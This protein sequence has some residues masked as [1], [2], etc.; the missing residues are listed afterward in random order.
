MLLNLMK[1]LSE[2]FVYDLRQFLL[3][4]HSFS[5]VYLH[6]NGE[7]NYEGEDDHFVDNVFS[8][9][10]GYIQWAEWDVK[11]WEIIRVPSAPSLS[12]DELE[13]LRE[14]TSTLGKT[15]PGPSFISSGFVAFHISRLPL[16]T[17]YLLHS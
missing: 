14:W 13:K 6:K 8:E 4:N 7:K 15:K 11:T 12:N 9:P 16:S 10:D 1:M 17:P 2:F 3:V 5:V